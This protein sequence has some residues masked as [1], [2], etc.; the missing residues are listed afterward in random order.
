MRQT[1]KISYVV[2]MQSI[3]FHERE[4]LGIEYL[5]LPECFG[6]NHWT[7]VLGLVQWDYNQSQ[8]LG[9]GWWFLVQSSS[10]SGMKSQKWENFDV[11][12]MSYIYIHGGRSNCQCNHK[13]GRNLTPYTRY[14]TPYISYIY[15]WRVF[16]RGCNRKNAR[17]LTHHIYD[18][19][20]RNSTPYVPLLGARFLRGS[21]PHLCV[22]VNTY[23][24]VNICVYTIC[25]SGWVRNEH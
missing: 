13:S 14:L 8:N 20:A 24:Y 25:N 2:F 6:S 10:A 5:R 1:R 12:Y 7:W 17:I 4:A 18:R 21:I 22:C 15:S 16:N 9:R 3:G 19:N 23:M 11:P